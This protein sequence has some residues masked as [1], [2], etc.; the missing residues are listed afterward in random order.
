MNGVIQD[1]IEEFELFEDQMDKYSHIVDMGKSLPVLEDRYKTED[2]VVKGCQS[3]VWLHAYESDGKVVYEADSNTAITK[4]IVAM[5][6]RVLSNRIP[7][8][9]LAEDMQFIE[10]IG[11]R[12]HLS[13]QR[14]N[15]LNS[16]IREMKLFAKA[17][18]Q[19]NEV[20]S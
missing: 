1:I 5:L 3:K 20:N 6:V 17:I 2:Y 4:G 16:M 14:S 11:L 19:K 7:D 10:T 15:G 13:S 8:E 18:K 12:S 9:I